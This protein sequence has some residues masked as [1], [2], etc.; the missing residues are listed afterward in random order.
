M[1]FFCKWL[2]SYIPGYSTVCHWRITF[3]AATEKVWYATVKGDGTVSGGK[4]ASFDKTEVQQISPDNSIMYEHSIELQSVPLSLDGEFLC[5]GEYLD[6]ND[7][8]NALDGQTIPL[9]V[10]G[11]YFLKQNTVKLKVHISQKQR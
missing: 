8:F 10:V 7:G 1:N 4:T 2:E 9:I 5:S 6:S 11:M 3:S